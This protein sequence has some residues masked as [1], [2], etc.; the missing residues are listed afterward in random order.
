MKVATNGERGER[1]KT[2]G[3]AWGSSGEN[4]ESFGKQIES[5][6]TRTREGKRQEEK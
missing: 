2:L 4:E 6:P 3:K 1:R 5:C